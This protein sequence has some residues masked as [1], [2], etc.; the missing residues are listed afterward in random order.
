MA[1]SRMPW[2]I[3]KPDI[4]H[5]PN[6]QPPPLAAG[7]QAGGTSTAKLINQ[8]VWEAALPTENMRTDFAII[9]FVDANHLF[10]FCNC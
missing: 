9:P 5:F 8:D 6:V 2:P 10:A 1:L 7:R 4:L 3:S